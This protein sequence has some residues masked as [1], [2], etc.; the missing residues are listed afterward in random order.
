L[1]GNANLT[2]AMRQQDSGCTRDWIEKTAGQTYITQAISYHGADD[3]AYREACHAELRPV[4]R[5]DW[6]DLT[7]LIEGEAI[8]LFGGRRIYARVF[9]GR[10]DDTGPK[11]LGRS[12]MLRSPTPHE[13]R[14]RFARLDDI[15]AT[16]ENGEVA[17]GP[18]EEVSPGLAALL[19]GF[20]KAAR[21]GE[22]AT[23][24]AR[25]AIEEIGRIPIE[26]LSGRPPL[27]ADGLPVTGVTPMLSAASSRHFGGP[28]S[29]GPPS[30]PIDVQLVR[31]LAA[32]EEAA[33]VSAS[34]AR[35]AALAIL[36]E[37]DA[38]LAAPVE[39]EPPPMTVETF[40]A[41]L[42]AVTRRLEALRDGTDLPRAA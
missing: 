18:E 1:L 17:L 16:I 31:K 38:A 3:G 11:R 6:N 35:C 41:H 25:H 40:Q 23:A 14:R 7:T 12:V 2:I 15:A 21:Q 13:V 42:A 30:E 27:V 34:A 26:L 37:R 9:H 20:T 4:P 24:C 19:Y 22:D 10:I 32:I 28:G 39:V 36:A 29:A 5:I 8:V 33:G